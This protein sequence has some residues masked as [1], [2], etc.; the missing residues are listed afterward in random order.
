VRTTTVQAVQALL[1][2]DYTA[3]VMFCQ[4]F[5]KQCGSNPNV[6]AFVIFLDE[7]QVTRDGIRIFTISIC[8]YM[9]IRM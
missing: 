7:A 2:Q 9:K 6:P 5:L 4:W 3:L 1:L 8:G